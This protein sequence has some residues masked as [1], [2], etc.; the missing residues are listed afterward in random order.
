MAFY[1]EFRY[2]HHTNG[3]S[4]KNHF[5]KEKISIY[6]VYQKSITGFGIVGFMRLWQ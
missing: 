3:Y 2:F 5:S 6:D 1:D 4:I